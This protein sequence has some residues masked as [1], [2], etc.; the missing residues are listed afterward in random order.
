MVFHIVLKL[1]N[2]GFNVPTLQAE[3]WDV[4]FGQN[5]TTGRSGQRKQMQQHQKLVELERCSYL[6]LCFCTTA[7][8]FVAQPVVEHC[9]R[10]I[11][12]R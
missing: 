10:Q 2:L 8:D 11:A 12:H 1:G 5:Q 6:N 9:V 3:Q 7:A 4:A